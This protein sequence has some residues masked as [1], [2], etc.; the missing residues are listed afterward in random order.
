MVMQAEDIEDNVAVT[1]GTK[2]V[3]GSNEQRFTANIPFLTWKIN[4]KIVLPSVWCIKDSKISSRSRFPIFNLLL[5][6][7]VTD[8]T[9]FVFKI[10][11]LQKT[12]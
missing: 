12:R 1:D 5:F 8:G 3:F 9:K 7:F 10:G 11:F 4:K 2:F 6:T